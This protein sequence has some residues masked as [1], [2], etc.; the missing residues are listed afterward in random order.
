MKP[1]SESPDYNPNAQLLTKKYGL[2]LKNDPIPTN[3]PLIPSLKQQQTVNNFRQQWISDAAYYKAAAR[4]FAPGDEVSDW[5]AA[6]QDY[7][8]MLV[9]SFLSVYKEDGVMT[10]IGLQ[11]LA[12]AIGI[13]RPERA[14]S[15]VKLIR[16]IQTACRQR[17]CFR[18]NPGEF[19]DHKTGCQWCNECQKLV[20]QWWR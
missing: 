18:I 3:K 15:K 13:Q 11:Q 10:I 2:L 7:T 14:D 17:P 6:E 4:E 5:L 12:Q 9:D 19:C 16:L 8:E 20:A 1:D